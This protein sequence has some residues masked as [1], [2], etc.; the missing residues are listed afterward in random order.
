MHHNVSSLS[1]LNKYVCELIAQCWEVPAKSAK[2]LSTKGSQM[3]P[4]VMLQMFLYWTSHD[5]KM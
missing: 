4:S 3:G 2:Y 5:P 1:A